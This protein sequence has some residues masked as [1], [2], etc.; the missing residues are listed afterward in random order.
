M[1]K[2]VIAVS[3]TA[4]LLALPL[5]GLAFNPGDQPNQVPGLNVSALID[6]IFSIIWPIVVA[7]AIIMFLMAAFMFFS[8]Q[9]DPEKVTMARNATVW[10][11][12]GMTV[13][14]IAFSIPSI[15]RTTIGNGI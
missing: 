6:V 9:G 15:V 3:A 13:A 8:S 11:I 2:K 14:L 4:L 1:N 7:F 10:G 12:V 5:M